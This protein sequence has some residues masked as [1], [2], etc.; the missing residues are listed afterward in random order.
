M[1][2]VFYLRAI[3]IAK[4]ISDVAYSRSSI[5]FNFYIHPQIRGKCA[6]TCHKDWFEEEHNTKCWA[7]I[8]YCFVV[9]TI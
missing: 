6:A 5:S 7:T 9:K 2:Y 4:D 1:V 8:I 3:V